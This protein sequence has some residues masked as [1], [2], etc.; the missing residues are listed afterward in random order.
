MSGR[1]TPG[2]ER[3]REQAFSAADFDCVGESDVSDTDEE[4]VSGGKCELKSAH[5]W[6][7]TAGAG[8][9]YRRVYILFCLLLAFIESFTKRFAQPLE[10]PF[11]S[12]I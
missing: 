7:Q 4:V 12:Y 2:K 1:G 10:D 5:W 6:N 11:E 3:Q 8:R 9:F